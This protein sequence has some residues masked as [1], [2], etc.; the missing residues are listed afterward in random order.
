[1]MHPAIRNT[2]IDESCHQ[3]TSIS[4]WT[5]CLSF[6][7]RSELQWDAYPSIPDHMQTLIRLLLKHI[8]II[9]SNSESTSNA[10]ADHKSIACNASSIT[11][12]HQPNIQP[13]DATPQNENQYKSEQYLEGLWV[14]KPTPK[15]I[16]QV[17][18]KKRMISE[19]SFTHLIDSLDPET[20]MPSPLK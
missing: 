20:P 2:T 19:S 13:F 9:E 6:L 16:N 8:V 17:K 3:R 1:M 5:L 12:H 4:T 14:H 11:S 18:Q 7:Y 10:A 15:K